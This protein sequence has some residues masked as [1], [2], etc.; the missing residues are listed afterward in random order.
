MCDQ[1]VVLELNSKAENEDP[2]MVRASIRHHIRDAEVFIPASIVQRGEQR[3]YHYLVDGYAFIK[4]RYPESY[5]RRLIETKYVLS[6]LFVPSSSSKER[7]LATI[8]SLEIDKFRSQIKIEVDQGIEIGDFVTITSG[9]YKNIKAIVKEEIPEQEAVVVYIQLRSTDR[10]VTLPRAFLQ[11]QSKS[12]YVIHKTKLEEIL[13]WVEYASKVLSLE[14]LESLDEILK[15]FRVFL[16]WDRWLGTCTTVYKLVSSYYT[17]FDF[18]DIQ[19]KLELFQQL[20]VMC[21]LQKEMVC[22]FN[23]LDVKRKQVS[24]LSDVSA[25][26][27]TIYADVQEIVMSSSLN[28]IIDGTQLFI[29]CFSAPGLDSLTTSDGRTTGTIIGFLRSLGALKKRFPEAAVWVCWDGSSQRR[30]AMCPEYKAN[31]TTPPRNE[32]TDVIMWREMDWL[33]EN[34]P[35]FGVFQA[36]N[37]KEE[38]DD[39]IASLVRGKFVD[40]L[41]VIVSTDRDLLQLVT[42]KTHQLC[43]KVGLGKEKLYDVAAVKEEFE[44]RPELFTHIRA[45][46]GDSSDNISGVPGFGLKTAS[47]LIKSYGTVHELLKSNLAGL[48]KAQTK[49]LVENRTQVLRNLDLLV[50][51]NVEYAQIRSNPNRDALKTKLAELEI[52]PMI[53]DSFFS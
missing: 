2:D 47:K 34:L 22:D 3:V 33:R 23:A 31:R 11:F 10:L 45:L 6:P 8:T 32:D 20:R 35:L 39:V 25:K 53:L 1:W 38:A 14:S 42:E 36:Y 19:R 46:S 13:R 41:N 43:P 24:F 7:K 52:G 15:S 29:R 48:G 9:P 5:Y 27:L 16:R 18:G 37:Q 12:P 21:S 49:A 51:Q 17:K 4:H 28:L 44:V 30:K 40:C 50:L 26:I